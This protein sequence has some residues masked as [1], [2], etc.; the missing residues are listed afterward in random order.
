MIQIIADSTCDLSPTLQN[1]MHIQTVPLTIHFGSE[2]YRDG[3][4]LTNEQFYS[5]L[6]QAKEL[7]STSQVPPGDFEDAFRPHVEAGKDVLAITLASGLSATYESAVTAARRVAPDKIHVVDSMSASFGH[8]LLLKQAVIMR[9]EGLLSAAQMADELRRLAPRI[10]LY[11]VV[12]TLK[13]LKM[14]GRLSG[15]AA[16]MGGLLSIKPLLYVQEGKVLSMAKVRGEKNVIKTLLEYFLKDNPQLQ[17]GV[18]F[19]NAVARPLM[20]QTIR[21]FKPH[22]GEAPVY[23]GDLGAVIGT[24]AGPGV[25]GVGFILPE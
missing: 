21:Q 14:G 3:I 6:A 5:K 8:V 13:Y 9:D 18:S 22:L 19:G 4:D 2:S 1:D 15:G 10:R 23:A 24:H 20:E 17:Y 12:D 16:L 7:P 25:V 11:A